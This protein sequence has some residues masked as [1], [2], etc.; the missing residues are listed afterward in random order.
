MYKKCT[1]SHTHKSDYSLYCM[2]INQCILSTILF[3]NKKDSLA[4]EPGHAEHSYILMN[5]VNH[6]L[7][8]IREASFK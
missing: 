5:Y 4:R 6:K 8:Y 2:L 1:E 7:C 3:A